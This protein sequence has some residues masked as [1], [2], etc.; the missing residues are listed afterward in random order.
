V[1]VV[2][3]EGNAVGRVKEFKDRGLPF[4]ERE[5]RMKNYGIASLWRESKYNHRSF[6]ISMRPPIK[7]Q[8]LRIIQ[9]EANP[10]QL[11]IKQ[12]SLHSRLLA[13]NCQ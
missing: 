8:I 9:D 5:L 4:M 1:Y 12:K 10:L 6:S 13:N 3:R 11:K 7:D 2:M